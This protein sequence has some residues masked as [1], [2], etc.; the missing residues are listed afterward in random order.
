MKN[1]SQVIAGALFAL[2]FA[3][4]IAGSLLLSLVENG[5]AIPAAPGIAETAPVYEI[6]P[7][8]SQIPP[9]PNIKQTGNAETAF[10]TEIIATPTSACPPLPGWVTHEVQ[11]GDTLAALAKTYGIDEAE[12]REGNCL[13]VS[14]PILLPGMTLNIPEKPNTP[15]IVPATD[16][17]APTATRAAPTKP[18]VRCAPPAGWVTYIVRPGDTLYSLSLAVGSSVP[19]LQ[20]ANCMGSATLIRTGDKILLPRYPVSTHIPTITRPP[21]IPP[22]L[23]PPASPAPTNTQAPV[24]SPTATQVLPPTSTNTSAPPPTNTLAPVP[25]NTEAPPPLPTDTSEMP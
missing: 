4:L 25:T 19:A 10:S 6:L 23:L 5:L 16:T 21:I 13:F 20:A 15:V 18:P 7:E 14:D 2:L 22:S 8:S 1:T 3:G 24:P 11:V 12:L 9:K 17:T